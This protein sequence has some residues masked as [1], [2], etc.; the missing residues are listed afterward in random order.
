MI[1]ISITEV[2]N[3]ETVSELMEKFDT[4]NELFSP[5]FLSYNGKTETISLQYRL[6]T[7]KAFTDRNEFFERLIQQYFQNP[8]LI[9][10]NLYNVEIRDRKTLR[11]LATDNKYFIKKGE[12]YSF[13]LSNLVDL[14]TEYI[15]IF[16][17][18]KYKL[19]LHKIISS[20]I[21]KQPKLVGKKTF[22]Y[23]LTSLM[24]TEKFPENFQCIDI[25]IKYDIKLNDFIQH[26]INK[27]FLIAQNKY[28]D[29]ESAGVRIS[30]EKG[31]YRR[32]IQN[33]FGIPPLKFNK[34][35]QLI[36]EDIV[37][38]IQKNFNKVIK[39]EII[40]G[41]LIPEIPEGYHRV[42]NTGQVILNLKFKTN[43][44]NKNL[45]TKAYLTFNFKWMKKIFKKYLPK[46]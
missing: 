8:I 23:D 26:F 16:I 6:R 3:F 46:K 9:P 38:Y 36:L 4:Y 13:N 28:L 27:K 32:M 10:S 11:N 42:E 45:I 31:E 12:F 17:D 37:H 34:R 41:N 14:E 39:I 20:H 35:I 33:R 21:S 44:S 15:D 1:K 7:F 25:P 2:Q 18:S 19:H 29:L 43:F 5:V 40:E 22:K 30:R 24:K